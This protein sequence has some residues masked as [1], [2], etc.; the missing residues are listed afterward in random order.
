MLYAV[1]YK[2]KK[3]GKDYSSLYQKL[4]DYDAWMHYIDNFWIIDSSKYANDISKD[5]LPLIDQ[6]NDYILIIQISRDYQGWLP[7]EAW[8]WINERIY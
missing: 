6:K 1:I 5:L 7:K 8:S 4:Q 3:W 2:L